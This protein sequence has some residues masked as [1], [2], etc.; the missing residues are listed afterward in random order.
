MKVSSIVSILA[1]A[2]HVLAGVPTRKRVFRIYTP[3]E[4]RRLESV[5]NRAGRDLKGEKPEKGP[6]PDKEISEMSMPAEADAMSMAPTASPDDETTIAT[7]VATV[8]ATEVEGSASTVAVPIASTVMSPPSPSPVR[9]IPEV[10]WDTN[11]TTMEDT[12]G[13]TPAPVISYIVETPAPVT[14]APFSLTP[15]PVTPA[16]VTPAPVTPAPVDPSPTDPPVSSESGTGG[17]PVSAI[18]NPDA[19]QAPSGAMAYRMTLSAMAVASIMFL[20]Y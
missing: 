11:A 6:K 3:D 8:A 5:E 9:D 16:P 15:A 13:P 19:V 18:T 14:P 7:T 2:D 4:I 12:P 10:V 20:L 17:T 1:L